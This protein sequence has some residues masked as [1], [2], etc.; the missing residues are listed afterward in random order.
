[1][2]RKLIRVALAAKEE[3]VNIEDRDVER[4]A[5]IDKFIIENELTLTERL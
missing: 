1:V 3:H 2:N 4:P 5:A